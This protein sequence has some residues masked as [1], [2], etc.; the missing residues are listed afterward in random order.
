MYKKK[1]VFYGIGY[2]GGVGPY[3][4]VG[5]DTNTGGTAWSSQTPANQSLF[6]NSNNRLNPYLSKSYFV[7]VKSIDDEIIDVSS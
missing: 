7:I 4:D 1:Q 6:Y 2:Y 3:I 5:T